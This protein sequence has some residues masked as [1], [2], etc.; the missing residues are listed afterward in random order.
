VV[1]EFNLEQRVE[2]IQELAKRIEKMERVLIVYGMLE[3]P[4]PPQKVIEVPR[5]TARNIV[6]APSMDNLVPSAL[7]TFDCTCGKAHRQ[8]LLVSL[9]RKR[10]G[11]VV[12]VTAECGRSFEV[13]IPKEQ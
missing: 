3:R 9:I 5:V 1:K 6:W 4:M 12:P 7:C 10:T 8:N 2:R 13:E 11:Q